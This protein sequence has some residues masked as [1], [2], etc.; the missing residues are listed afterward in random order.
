MKKLKSERNGVFRNSI[1]Y[2][3]LLKPMIY[4]F[5]TYFSQRTECKWDS[6]I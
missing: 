4:H 1:F 2:N 5:R 6:D 3:Q